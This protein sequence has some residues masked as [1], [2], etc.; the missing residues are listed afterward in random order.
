MSDKFIWKYSKTFSSQFGV[1][2]MRKLVNLGYTPKIGI[3]GKSGAGKSSLGNAILGR[4]VF[5][6]GS[7]G[8]CTR[9]FQEE[10]I[11]IGSRDIVFV[12]LPGIAENVQRNKEYLELYKKKLPELDVI[13]WVIKIDDRANVADEQFYRFLKDNYDK[14]Q[15]LFVLSQADKAEPTY[16]WDHKRMKP[17]EDQLKTIEANRKRISSDFKVAFDDVVA[18]SAIYEEE[19]SKF[20]NYYFDKLIRKI[21]SKIPYRYRRSKSSP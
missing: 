16:K 10:T 13:L 11:R 1:F 4:S 5:K 19:E 8:G 9:V 18:V 12:D 3:M 21:I 7:C 6:T 14:N 20:K 2:L 15:I 17:S